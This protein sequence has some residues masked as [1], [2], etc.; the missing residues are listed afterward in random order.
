MSA[1]S[2]LASNFACEHAT[3]DTGPA[4]LTMAPKAFDATAWE[5]EFRVALDDPTKWAKKCMNLRKVMLEFVVPRLKNRNEIPPFIVVVIKAMSGSSLTNNAEGVRKK[6]LLAISAPS[7]S[8]SSGQTND[9]FITKPFPNGIA[10]GPAPSAFTAHDV[11]IMGLWKTSLSQPVNAFQESPETPASGVQTPKMKSVA[12][13]PPFNQI[14]QTQASSA[15]PLTRI[16]PA[17]TT[18]PK[19]RAAHN[20]ITATLEKPTSKMTITPDVASAMETIATSQASTLD[21]KLENASVNV[22]NRPH[23]AVNGVSVPS[24]AEPIG[25]ATSSITLPFVL[26]LQSAAARVQY[27][28]ANDLLNME[29]ITGF[30]DLGPSSLND[31]QPA[32][33]PVQPQQLSQKGKGKAV[34]C[35]PEPSQVNPGKKLSGLDLEF[36]SARNERITKKVT[37]EHGNRTENG[38]RRMGEPTE[39]NSNAIFVRPRR[40]EKLFV[41]AALQIVV[42]DP[43][44]ASGEPAEESSTDSDNAAVRQGKKDK[45]L[46]VALRSARSMVVLGLHQGGT[47]EKCKKAGVACKAVKFNQMCSRCKI[48][49]TR[50]SHVKNKGVIGRTR[51]RLNTDELDDDGEPSAEPSAAPAAVVDVTIRRSKRTATLKGYG[52]PGIEKGRTVIGRTAAVED[53]GDAGSEDEDEPR[54]PDEL[55]STEPVRQAD[56]ANVVNELE[57]ANRQLRKE[58]SQLKEE[59]MRLKN[60]SNG[61]K[62]DILRTKKFTTQWAANLCERNAIATADLATVLN[63][64]SPERSLFLGDEPNRAPAPVQNV[65]Q[66]GHTP[67]ASGSGQTHQLEVAAAEATVSVE[68]PLRGS[69][70][71]VVAPLSEQVATSVP[72][73]GIPIGPSAKRKPSGSPDAATPRGSK[74][75]RDDAT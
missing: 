52:A 7:R 11:P 22:Q 65:L 33:E 37:G 36:S 40:D 26:P 46:R 55:A 39:A 43:D 41:P 50:C 30:L 70:L 13:P 59:N 5:S 66:F 18:P 34:T 45:E 20:I 44:D 1:S 3:T 47:C 67:G 57:E 27:M 14:R 56:Q 69:R 15:G 10:S 17:P 51:K 58:N 38:N 63:G 73:E 6:V 60:E 68:V 2:V 9:A 71:S 23:E 24:T 8:S 42:G 49:K 32:N 21:G 53:N 72:S 48:K 62:A 29:D 31:D 19:L 64:W 74:R 4:T 61:L 75:L 25:Q 28:S 12:E 16:R 54:V 35:E